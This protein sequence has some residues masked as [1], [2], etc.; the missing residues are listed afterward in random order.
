[1]SGSRKIDVGVI[2]CGNMGKMYIQDLKASGYVDRIVGYDPCSQQREKMIEEFQIEVRDNL[3][4]MWNER[5]LKL[6]CI[7]SPG[8][9]HAELA[10]EAMRRGKSVL[11]EKPM[12]LT[13]EELEHV[14]AVQQQTGA[15]LQVGFEARYSTLYILVKKI[16]DSGEIGQV[17]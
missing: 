16:I 4:S 1:M 5:D 10:T 17:P 11:L 2:G 12:G 7:V 6:V 9:T 14:L 13:V 15:F 3:E 8:R